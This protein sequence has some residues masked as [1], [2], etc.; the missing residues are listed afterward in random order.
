MEFLDCTEEHLPA[1]QGFY[2]KN[3]QPNYLFLNE[4]FFDWLFK[5]NPGNSGDTYS[6]KLA[7]DGIDVVGHLGYIPVTMAGP[8]SHYQACW[9]LNLMV[10]PE[11][12]GRGLGS[13][14]VMEV[15][16]MFEITAGLGANAPARRIYSRLG[17]TDFGCLK[18]YILIC[19]PYE[20]R[21]MMQ[22]PENRNYPWPLTSNGLYT[23][24]EQKKVEILTVKHF[25]KTHDQYLIPMSEQIGWGTVR[26]SLYLNWRYL[27]HPIFDYTCLIAV[28]PPS[29]E[30]VEGLVVFR[31]EKIRD[32]PI[33]VGHIVELIASS[34]ALMPLL[35]KIIEIAT[36]DNLAIVDFFSTSDF[37]AD[38]LRTVGFL[39]AEL[40]PWGEIPRLFQPI[41]YRPLGI[42]FV[43][44]AQSKE[45]QVALS[46]MGSWYVT[47]GD[48]DQD[49]PN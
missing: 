20:V 4:R 12:R 42:T 10:N 28:Q 19:N 44:T 6:V 14:L 16:R 22:D 43:F 33:R 31:T 17:W 37:Y 30:V 34:V 18:R 36:V 2:A 24:G 15:A 5:E 39:P 46:E 41:D 25:D 35:K 27:N 9:L 21:I 32:M 45:L 26:S 13:Q 8:Q 3:Y 49:R 48:G 23:W 29:R 7:M 11:Y 47:K 40:H 1:L 38:Q